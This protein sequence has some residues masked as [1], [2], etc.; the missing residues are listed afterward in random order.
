MS[1]WFVRSTLDLAHRPETPPPFYA[2]FNARFLM[3]ETCFLR[4]RKWGENERQKARSRKHFRR[5]INL[6]WKQSEKFD[7]QIIDAPWG[8]CL[9][10]GSEDVS[11][12]RPQGPSLREAAIQKTGLA[13][14]ACWSLRYGGFGFELNGKRFYI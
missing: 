8:V 14:Y 9:E 5:R 12:G 13:P 10:K 3:Q 7:I 4:A 11:N 2:V 6:T 1:A